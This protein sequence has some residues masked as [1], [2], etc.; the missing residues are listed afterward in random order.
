[1]RLRWA[2]RRKDAV[3][4]HGSNSWWVFSGV[5]VTGGGVAR[6]EPLLFNRL[7]SCD[8][9]CDAEDLVDL[10]L[11]LDDCP[12]DILLFSGSTYQSASTASIMA[13]CWVAVSEM[14]VYRI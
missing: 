6:A 13:I 5:S 4:A 1:M 11:C 2:Y 14:A 9:E 7:P 12:D 3:A 8:C 10:D